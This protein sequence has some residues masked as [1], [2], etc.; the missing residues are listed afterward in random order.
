MPTWLIDIPILVDRKQRSI[1]HLTGSLRS[2]N[3]CLPTDDMAWT[4]YVVRQSTLSSHPLQKSTILEE[5]EP[6]IDIMSNR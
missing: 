1:E 5:N 2:P 3:Q 6:M 4:R